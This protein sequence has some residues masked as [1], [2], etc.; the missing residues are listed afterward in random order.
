MTATGSPWP[1]SARGPDMDAGKTAV[2]LAK[3]LAELL[4]D[5]A[6]G[7]AVCAECWRDWASAAIERP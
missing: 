3:L 6:A 7:Y 2:I 4:S 1:G 5:N